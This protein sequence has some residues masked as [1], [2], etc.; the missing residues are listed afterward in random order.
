M[1]LVKTKPRIISSEMSSSFF[2]YAEYVR[3]D[4]NDT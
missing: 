3:S 4:I 2:S 1:S